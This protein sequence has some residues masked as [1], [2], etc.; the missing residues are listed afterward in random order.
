M[1]PIQQFSVSQMV[2]A[3][4][5]LASWRFRKAWSG[6]DTIEPIHLYKALSQ[7]AQCLEGKT[8]TEDDLARLKCELPQ[9]HVSPLI[10]EEIK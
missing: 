5:F 3:T 6:G 8:S 7:F 9:E 10:A 2:W 1:Q 4:L